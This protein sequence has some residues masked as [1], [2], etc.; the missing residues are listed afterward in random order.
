MTGNALKYFS[1][2][3]R[4]CPPHPP[5][6]VPPFRALEERTRRYSIMHWRKRM[7]DGMAMI[8]GTRYC[9]PQPRSGRLV[10]EPLWEKNMQRETKRSAIILA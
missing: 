5:A 8:M 3:A 6:P 10:A 4:C 9:P 7:R 2:L 1:A